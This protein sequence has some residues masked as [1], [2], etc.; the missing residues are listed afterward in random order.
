MSLT[1]RRPA[2][3]RRSRE[4]PEAT[5]SPPLPLLV[6]G[7][8]AG[9]VAALVSYALLAV[10]ALGAWMLDPAAPWE[11][12]HMLEAASAG[13]L[14]GQGVPLVIAET[15][16][17]VPPLGFGL[18]C[19]L[20]LAAATRWAIGAAAVAR[21]GE[22]VAVSVSSA[23]TY[24]AGA[25]IVVAL[26]QHLGAVPWLAGVVCGSIALVISAAT[27]IARVPLIRANDLS[28]SS[29][30]AVSAAVV[31]LMILV[32]AAGLALA[33]MIVI[34]ADE[35]G[36]VMGSLELGAAGGLLIVALTVGYL[37]VA[38]VWSLAY[39][40]GPGF[41]VSTTSTVSAFGEAGSAALPGLP[42]LAAIPPEPPVAAMTLPL[43]GVLAGAVMGLLLRRRGWS[44]LTGIAVG[45]ASSAIVALTVGLVSWASGGSLGAASLSAVGPT[46]YLV[47]L[48]ALGTTLLGTAAVVVWPSTDAREENHG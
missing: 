23:V 32:I 45:A 31:G 37:P 15:P 26:G 46:P 9:A 33:A 8:V 3:G 40:L 20:A 47:G 41:A 25:A 14:S 11:W 27:M 28:P 39:L 30:D 10:I 48:A 16:I 12:S 18:V 43:V 7:A 34:H 36:R 38:M 29:L 21:R 17:S 13:W 6:A 35:V 2:P 5:A 4:R 24:G 22:A 42:M 19:L 44:G 1:E